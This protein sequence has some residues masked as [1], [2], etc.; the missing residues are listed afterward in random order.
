MTR[1]DGLVGVFSPSLISVESQVGFPPSP[2]RRLTY[3]DCLR[4]LISSV[5]L[6]EMDSRPS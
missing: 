2:A 3:L 5:S 4:L 1:D 6:G